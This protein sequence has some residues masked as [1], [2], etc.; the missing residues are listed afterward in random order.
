MKKPHFKSAKTISPVQMAKYRAEW[1]R[2]RK[3]LVE[4]GDFSAA[5]AD[6]QRGIIHAEVLGADKSSKDF[7]NQELN[8]VLDAFDKILVI[9][10]GPSKKLSRT[11]ANYIYAIE[12][13]GLDE[14]YIAKIAADQFKI[15][16]WRKLPEE[17]LRI[18]RFTC[19]RAAARR[20]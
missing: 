7:T 6:A 3:C 4:F 14:P 20:A 18:F 13:L 10:D 19:T 12:Q 17:R 1:A 15:S 8:C 9:M 5:D 11:A 2:V 16:D